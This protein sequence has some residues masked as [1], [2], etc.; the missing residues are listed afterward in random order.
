MLKDLR[1]SG[2]YKFLTLAFATLTI[3]FLSLCSLAHAA[4]EAPTYN[5]TLLSESKY[6]S[7]G[8]DNLEDSALLSIEGTAEWQGATLGLWYATGESEA[9]D[10]LNVF[11]EYGFELGIVDA[12][13]GY[14]RLE[15][16]EDDGHDNEISVG[17]AI[18]SLAWL[19]PALDYVYSTEADAG[20]LE[21]SLRAEFKL[22]KEGPT[23][24]FYVL[25]GFDFGYAS[26]DYDGSNNVQAGI[27]FSAALTNRLSLVGSLAHSWA[28]EDVKKEGLGDKTWVSI[29]ISSD[30]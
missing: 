30:F 10:E 26:D 17:I 18:N 20:F 23:F 8:R 13:L 22:C 11:I 7:E 29:G 5:M 25:E 2:Y 27:E 21:V 15:F 19:T 12:S 9:Y 16:L 4:S 24:E 1:Q 6:I 14:T 3:T 28:L